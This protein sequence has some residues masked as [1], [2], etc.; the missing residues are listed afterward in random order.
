MQIWYEAVCSLRSLAPSIEYEI[1]KLN[2]MHIVA[3]RFILSL[4]I[5]RAFS[6]NWLQ[7][8]KWWKEISETHLKCVQTW[9][10]HEFETTEEQQQQK[11]TLK[12]QLHKPPEQIEWTCGV[13]CL[14]SFIDIIQFVY[15]RK[16]GELYSI[17][18]ILCCW[19]L[20]CSFIC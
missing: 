17:V 12:T 5:Y 3:L 10:R 11:S 15:E 20:V 18:D 13:Y 19:L 2:I 6:S 14:L 7:K 4:F 8:W 9:N 1:M 16:Y